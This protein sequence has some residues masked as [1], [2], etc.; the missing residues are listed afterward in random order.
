[1]S[2]LRSD[3]FPVGYRHDRWV[4]SGEASPEVQAAL[5][6]VTLQTIADRLG[7]SRMTVSNAFSRPDQLSPQMRRRILAAADELGYV[8]PDPT[9]RALARGSAGAVGV[10]LTESVTQ[11]F[12]DEVATGFLGAVA[13]A[14]EPTGLALTLL[15]ASSGPTIPARDVAIDAAIV[16][17]CQPDSEALQWL[18]RRHLP[19]VFVDQTPVDGIPSINIDDRAGARAA[20]RHL[21][22]LGHRRIGIVSSSF[23]GPF[24]LLDQPGD[25]L[26]GHVPSLRLGGWLEELS[27][28]DRR[29]TVVV[30]RPNSASGS[31]SAK[32][33]LDRA[34]PPTAILC[35]SDVIALGVIETA[36]DNGLRVPDDLSVVGFDDAPLAARAAPRLTT[37]RQDLQAKGRLAATALTQELARSAAQD[38]TFEALHAVLPTSLVVRDST[39]RPAGRQSRP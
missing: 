34:E 1:M 23:H 4:A 32:L 6:R 11:A 29:P 38:T 24:G 13:A 25:V 21:I 17:S 39:A 2:G 27:A 14:L 37:I 33:L 15:T 22:D 5:S 20:A 30:Q 19:L 26:D 16:Y 10:L 9:A 36:R 3:P 35:F 8:G 12:A 31:D 28:A 18:V 7:V